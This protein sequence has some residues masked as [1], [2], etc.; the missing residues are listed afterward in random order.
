MHSNT[1]ENK[2]KLFRRLKRPKRLQKG[3]LRQLL[4][5][6]YALLIVVLF[7]AFVLIL[8]RTANLHLFG[9]STHTALESS[10]SSSELSLSAP[11]GDIVDR[12]GVPLA[13]TESIN[14]ISIVNVGM[15]NSAFNRMLL[16]LAKLFEENKVETESDFRTYLDISQADRKALEEGA[17]NVTNFVFKRSWEEIEVFQTNSDTFNLYTPEEASNLSQ[18][19]RLV[20]QTPREFFDF[21][22]YDFFYIEPVVDEGNRLYSDY[23]AFQIMELR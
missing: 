15:D 21:L 8:L 5:N 9:Q 17:L 23:E 20:K 1:S 16:D 19:Q 11:R 4:S 10:G 2:D 14:T 6:R 3:F 13:V 7:S 18:R 12:N 22:L